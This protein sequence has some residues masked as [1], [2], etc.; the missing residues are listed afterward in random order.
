MFE[1]V[2][3]ERLRNVAGV[4]ALIGAAGAMRAYPQVAEK[5][6][7][8]PYATYFRVSTNTEP[9]ASLEGGRAQVAWARIQFDAWSNTYA[10]AKALDD[11]IRLALDGWSGTYS[12]VTVVSVRR[13]DS[14]DIY[15]SETQPPMH[16]VSSDYLVCFN[17]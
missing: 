7:A 2:L 5:N 16:R 1:K 15:E 4:T 13:V 6:A 8:I 12:G 17:L 3:V 11:A 10:Q 14:R 9:T